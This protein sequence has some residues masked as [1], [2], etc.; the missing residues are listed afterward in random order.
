MRW[1]LLLT[2]IF[3]LC[4]GCASDPP[5]SVVAPTCVA[6]APSQAPGSVDATRAY[7]PWNPT[8]EDGP[9]RPIHFWA[10]VFDV[11]KGVTQGE[12]QTVAWTDGATLPTTLVGWT[13]SMQKIRDNAPD[14]RISR[15]PV[16]KIGE[17]VCS[18]PSGSAIAKA[19]CLLK[20]GPVDDGEDV[21]I[22]DAAGH[23]ARLHAGCRNY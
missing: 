2:A 9:A 5:A 20:R 14:K 17:I 23:M 18:C 10:N 13:C 4:A 15:G 12:G 19:S 11:Y 16:G 8:A 7:V 21:T 3:G 1:C 6:T 22:A